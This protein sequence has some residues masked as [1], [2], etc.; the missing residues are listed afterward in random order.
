MTVVGKRDCFRIVKGSAFGDGMDALRCVI[1][2]LLGFLSRVPVSLGNLPLQ[3]AMAPLGCESK[4]PPQ[5]GLTGNRKPQLPLTCVQSCGCFSFPSFNMTDAVPASVSSRG[6][7]PVSPSLRPV[8]LE[9][10]EALLSWGG[11]NGS[12]SWPGMCVSR[13]PSFISCVTDNPELKTQPCISCSKVS[14]AQVSIL[15][16]FSSPQVLLYLFRTGAD[17]WTARC[18]E[19]QRVVRKLWPS[20]RRS[21]E[22][23]LLPYREQLGV[24][25]Y[26]SPRQHDSHF[27]NMRWSP[28]NFPVLSG[29]HKSLPV[30][31][32][33]KGNWAGAGSWMF[34]RWMGSAFWS[35]QSMHHV[36]L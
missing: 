20:G 13:T 10:R 3:S 19:W 31:S 11:G 5:P 27:R 8:E 28:I 24:S 16:R 18:A 6:N 25:N 2:V 14:V 32:Q 9:V 23:S 34:L 35:D 1:E 7:V 21:P 33:C 36:I 4:H 12:G 15:V 22:L 17:H 30:F 29:G 26:S